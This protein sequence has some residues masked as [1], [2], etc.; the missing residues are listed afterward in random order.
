MLWD[1]TKCKKSKDETV[2]RPKR[3]DDRLKCG[4]P[5]KVASH[6]DQTANSTH[7]G[8]DRTR[9]QSFTTA[10]AEQNIGT[11]RKP[12]APLSGFTEIELSDNIASIT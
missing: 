9:G 4:D 5:W 7:A 8:V 6:C 1:Y 12:V 3:C 2:K 10:F 11:G